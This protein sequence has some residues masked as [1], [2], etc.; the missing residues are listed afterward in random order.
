MAQVKDKVENA[1][2]ET[3]ILVL[4]IQILIGFDFKSFF[5]PGFSRMAPYTQEI[6]VAALGLMLV[7]FG[8]LMLP[9]SFHRIVLHGRNTAGFHRLGT[10]TVSAG[11]FPFA[12]AMSLSF[13]LGAR[14]VLGTAGAAI[15]G[16]SVLLA[17]LLGWY[18]LELA[19]RRRKHGRIHLYAI[20]D[21]LR[22]IQMSEEQETDLTTRVKQVLIECRVVLP[23][24]QALLGFQLIIMW[25]TEFYKIPQS[26]KLLHLASLLSVAVSTIL[27]ILP[28]AY[29][30]IV[31][32]GEDSEMLHHITARA[33]LAAMVFL[34]L[35]ICGDFYVVCRMTGIGTILSTALSACLLAFFYGAWFGYT[36]WKKRAIRNPRLTASHLEEHRAA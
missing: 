19:A 4:G 17:T 28:A 35:G 22:E 5:E 25:M 32:Q 6:Q 18:V 29:H 12:L 8:V 13:F 30:R 23:G 2:N 24:A 36:Y 27:L 26:W 1:L 15:V 10:L 14:W 34:A 31:E 11:L 9:V 7:G 3:R 16:G 33:L 20:F 21:P